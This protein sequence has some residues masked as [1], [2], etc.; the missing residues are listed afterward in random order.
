MSG[1]GVGRSQSVGLGW[2]DDGLRAAARIAIESP[3]AHLA[4]R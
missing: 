4:E 1:V 2:P 3:D